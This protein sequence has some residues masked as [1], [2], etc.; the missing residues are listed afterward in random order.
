MHS[1][2]TTFVVLAAITLQGVFGSLQG[3]VIICLGGGHEHGPA[4]V[5]EHCELECSHHS[6]WPTQEI[7]EQ[8]IDDCDCTDF[9][10]GLIT[11]LTTPPSGDQDLDLAAVPAPAIGVAQY[12][13]T[14]YSPRSPTQASRGDP[15]GQ[16]RLACIRSTRLLV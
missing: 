3:S 4:E 11:L 1:S 2:F 14:T 15:S 10:L 13:H 6:D 7:D 8:H 9:E 12:V 5:I 16:Q